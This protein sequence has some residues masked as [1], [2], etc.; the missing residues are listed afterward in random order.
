MDIEDIP[1]DGARKDVLGIE[2]IVRKRLEMLLVLQ[3]QRRPFV[4]SKKQVTLFP[5]NTCFS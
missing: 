2:G 4:V 1:F 3:K 5:C